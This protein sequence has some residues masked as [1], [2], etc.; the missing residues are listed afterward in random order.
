M[1]LVLG[2]SSLSLEPEATRLLEQIRRIPGVTIKFYPV[3][4]STGETVRAN[5]NKDGPID[6]FGIRGDAYTGWKISWKW[7][8]S[9]NG[10][11]NIKAVSVNHKITVTLP[12][13]TD[14]GSAAPELGAKWDSYFT[15]MLR[16]ELRHI[17]HVIDHSK[18]IANEIRK[19]ANN[20][21]RLTT[22]QANEIAEQQL[23]F[24][25][26]LDRDYDSSTKRGATEGVTFP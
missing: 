5:L 25:R 21:P 15:A 23:A 3:S 22:E 14:R 24:I 8:R 13:W 19:A 20:N 11:A 9:S 18:S 6:Q 26:Q 7:P 16:H 10:S 4:G 17:G 12:Q 1:T 2:A